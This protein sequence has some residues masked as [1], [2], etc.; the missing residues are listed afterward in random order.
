[1]EAGSRAQ[2]A[3]LAFH[4]QIKA[5]VE[6]SKASLPPMPILIKPLQLQELEAKIDELHLELEGLDS[7]D[8]DSEAQRQAKQESLVALSRELRPLKTDWDRTCRDAHVAYRSQDEMKA[9]SLMNNI[10]NCYKDFGL[11]LNGNMGVDTSALGLPGDSPADADPDTPRRPRMRMKRGGAVLT[12]DRNGVFESD[13][14]SKRKRAPS[15]AISH[16]RPRIQGNRNSIH[17]NA[18]YQ[19]KRAAKK[20][21]II[22]VPEHEDPVRPPRFYIL[23]CENHDIDFNDNPLQSGLAHLSQAHQHE[24]PSFETVVQHFGYELIGCDDEKLIQNNK[25]ANEAFQKGQRGARDFIRVTD[26]PTPK[27]SRKSKN[28]S[29]AVKKGRSSRKSRNTINP[30]DLVP[31]DVY[32]VYWSQS[33]Q[34]YCGLLIPLQDPESVG[35]EESLEALGLLNN[36]PPCYEYDS[37]SKSFSWA[38]GYEDGGEDASEQHFPFMFFEG[39][40]FPDLCHVAWIPLDEIQPL[41]EEKALMIEH[42]HQAFE[43]LK[44]RE[45]AQRPKRLGP[46]DEIPDSADDNSTS[47]LAPR[48]PVAESSTDFQPARNA[49]AVTPNTAPEAG[50]ADKAEDADVTGQT[51]E[52][53]KVAE[54]APEEEQGIL[55]ELKETQK[56]P[57][58]SPEEEQETQPEPEEAQSAQLETE[59]SKDPELKSEEVLD[60]LP[61]PEELQNDSTLASVEVQNDATLE[62]GEVQK[63]TQMEV[64]EAQSVQMEV[65]DS[66]DTRPEPEKV[67]ESPVQPDIVE[68]EDIT[69]SSEKSPTESAAQQATEDSEDIVMETP[70][71]STPEP[72]Q[73]N[74]SQSDREDQE[75]ILDTQEDPAE[76]VSSTKEPEEVTAEREEESSSHEAREERL[77]SVD[78]ADLLTAGE[79]L[80]FQFSQSE[81][82]ELDQRPTPTP[83]HETVGSSQA[84]NDVVN[85]QQEQSLSASPTP[86]TTSVTRTET[87]SEHETREASQH[88]RSSVATESSNDETPRP[89]LSYAEMGRASSLSEGVPSE[90]VE[91][92]PQIQPASRRAR[93][94]TPIRNAL[95][96]QSRMS[97]LSMSPVV[98]RPPAMSPPATPFSPT[99]PSASTPLQLPMMSQPPPSS[100]SS[101]IRSP[102]SQRPPSGLQHP[103]SSWPLDNS[104]ASTTPQRLGPSQPSAL[105]RRPALSQS[106]AT[107]QPPPS[108]QPPAARPSTLSRT[109]SLSQPSTSEQ[110]FHAPTAQMGPAAQVAMSLGPAVSNGKQL[111]NVRSTSQVLAHPRHSQ[112]EGPLP[113]QAQNRSE[114]LRHPHAAQHKA[115]AQALGNAPQPK[116]LPRAIKPKAPSK[117]TVEIV[118]LNRQAVDQARSQSMITGQQAAA[119]SPTQM[120]AAQERHSEPAQATPTPPVMSV[121]RPIAPAARRPLPQE[122]PSP[123]PSAS[124]VKRR[125]AP[126][127]MPSQKQPPS[128]AE[129]T[130]ATQLE[131]PAQVPSGQ[132]PARYASRPASPAHQNSPRL[133]PMNVPLE[134]HYIPN[135][136]LAQQQASLSRPGSSG[137]VGPQ[138]MPS[139]RLAA[140]SISRP[141][142]ASQMHIRSQAMPSPHQLAAEVQRPQ[143][144]FQ[145]HPGS[146]PMYSPRQV[147][148]EI[149]HHNHRPVPSPRRPYAVPVQPPPSP[150]QPF[151]HFPHR[152]PQMQ[153]N[154]YVSQR[155]ASTGTLS[156]QSST[157]ENQLPPIRLPNISRP[158]SEAHTGPNMISPPQTAVGARS[159]HYTGH[160]QPTPPIMQSPRLSAAEISRPHTASNMR[161]PLATMS[162][163]LGQTEPRRPNSSYSQTMPFHAPLPTMQPN[164]SGTGYQ[165]SAPSAH[166]YAQPNRP[167]GHLR[168]HSE[169]A[170]QPQLQQYAL[171]GSPQIANSTPRSYQSH[172][173]D[174]GP[175]RNP[176]LDPF[177]SEL[178]P[179]VRK[180][181]LEQVGTERPDL[182][183]CDFLNNENRYRCPFCKESTLDPIALINHIKM[184]CP[185]LEEKYKQDKIEQVFEANRGK[186]V[187]PAKRKSQMAQAAKNA[188][189]RS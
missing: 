24:N 105:A 141:S 85:T 65:E 176:A 110:P 121:A 117:P 148:G 116:E 12:P 49:E 177:L 4:E 135:T 15:S 181:L 164:Y 174:Q 43:Y 124:P 109:S 125:E 62:S 54:G 151:G 64:E 118:L 140:G 84:A 186:R 22:R 153:G 167:Q 111:H 66:Q 72:L 61:E 48:S 155:H 120:P 89:R 30:R 127:D 68:D 114:V 45:A 98:S 162:P 113:E 169:S 103:V 119:T 47:D 9:N 189:V 10:L 31:G 143:S 13:T 136:I 36:I 94:G 96:A 11:P 133:P 112:I 2:S 107:S 53:L 161:P 67:A 82:R 40:D 59:E 149:S 27:T 90:V 129:N 154:G 187:K 1:M 75:I 102:T 16:K 152:S 44:Q 100:Q 56:D 182:V 52:T 172:E 25:V 163:V 46:N 185:M 76:N 130:P 131:R 147:P 175:R 156:P 171:A 160:Q 108:S 57:E 33:K 6:A 158:R 122:R 19:N 126:K 69:M 38:E 170:Y 86:E 173:L 34:W 180:A 157:A 83:A 87:D 60:I 159:G 58:G 8:E 77:P 32:I 95:A 73:Q 18:V 144:S 93:S 17:F 41:D 50:E 134:G 137:H 26:S 179:N 115:S 81:Q 3:G 178:S 7:D 21:T 145:G 39:L 55:P 123:R 29:N 166:Q 28:S 91:S 138:P 78:L 184:S 104:W 99:A 97:S 79:D 88:Q 188:R 5:L 92:R 165:S 101:A 132:P 139:P 142:S 20:H 150:H 51:D 63:D 42:S 183:P 74:D 128:G 37:S 168:R 80:E 71:D 146:Q 23:R 106:T 14:R 35:I 70:E